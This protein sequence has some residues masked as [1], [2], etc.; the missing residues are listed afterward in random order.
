MKDL[1]IG[2]FNPLFIE[3]AFATLLSERAKKLDRKVFQSSFHRGSFCDQWPEHSSIAYHL[4]SFNPLFIEE[5][6]AT[7][8]LGHG[9]GQCREGVSILFSSRK[10]LR[11]TSHKLSFKETIMVSIL[12]SSRKLLRPQHLPKPPK[13]KPKRF[14]PLFIEEA[15]ATRGTYEWT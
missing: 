8:S 13:P 10:L 6:F 2:G 5:A 1:V 12:F 3:E 11:L 9:E 4:Q 7:P 15:F 14:N